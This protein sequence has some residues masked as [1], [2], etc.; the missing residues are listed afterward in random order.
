M[1]NKNMNTTVKWKE[2]AGFSNYECNEQGQFR[3]KTSK[4]ILHQSSVHN[5]YIHIG[6]IN[7]GKQLWRLAHRL[8][9]ETW[10][11]K[12]DSNHNIVNHINHIRSDNRIENLEWVTRSANAK[13]KRKN[14]PKCPCCNQPLYNTNAGK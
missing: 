12:P 8:L 6:L 7:N 11:K 9:A 10:L 1:T 5:G 4:R 3:N 14:T 13:N 2:V